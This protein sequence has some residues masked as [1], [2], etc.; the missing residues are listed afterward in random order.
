MSHLVNDTVVDFVPPAFG[1]VDNQPEVW[2][3]MQAIENQGQKSLFASAAP[4]LLVGDDD[5]P[6]FFWEAEKK[7]LGRALPSWNQG[8][9]GSCVAFGWGRGCQ[10]LMLWQVATGTTDKHPEHDVAAEPIYGGS[11]VE[12]GGG[13]IGGDGSIG[14]WAAK[15][16]KDWGVLLRKIYT[17]G[18]KTY[19]LSLYSE[20]RCRQYGSYGCPDDLE[21]EARL[22]PVTSVAMVRNAAEAWAA[23]GA[24]KPVPV[25]SDRGFTTRLNQ[26]FCEPS[27]TWNHCML[28][29]G[30]FIHPSRGKC[31]V[32]Q[33][34]WGG[35]LD[36]TGSDV[37]DVQGRGNVELPQGCFATTFN[38]VDYICR[39]QDSFAA[40]GLKGWERDNQIID[41]TP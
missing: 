31:F 13:Q 17:V 2:K 41:H 28:L 6:L 19:D 33:N 26:G 23:V 35:Y 1:W 38:V 27:G 18:N 25:C 34:S 24:G 20:S 37:I 5:A 15:W 11:R 7:I 4:E 39:Q 8:S 9:V 3:M 12:V 10:D 40:A 16:V 30:R 22:H 32:I 36:G 29:R 21:P 14:A